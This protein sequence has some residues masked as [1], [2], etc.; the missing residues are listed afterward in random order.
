M[1]ILTLLWADEDD[2]A[3]LRQL[4]DCALAFSGKGRMV[5]KE[6]SELL[7]LIKMNCVL[8]ARHKDE[9]MG[10]IA[11]VDCRRWE[12]LPL[13]HV[14]LHRLH[15]HPEGPQ[16]EIREQLHERLVAECAK[17]NIRLLTATVPVERSYELDQM[18]KL[19]YELNELPQLL[20]RFP[21]HYHLQFKGSVKIKETQIV[22]IE[23]SLPGNAKDGRLAYAA[24]NCLPLEVSYESWQTKGWI[25]LY[26]KSEVEVASLRIIAMTEHN[27][28]HKDKHHR[29]E[30]Q[31]LFE[32]AL[33]I[34]K[35]LHAK[36]VTAYFAPTLELADNPF[37]RALDA[38]AT[39][40]EMAKS[41]ELKIDIMPS[42]PKSAPLFSSAEDVQNLLAALDNEELFG[43]RLNDQ[44]LGKVETF[45][46]NW[47]N[48]LAHLQISEPKE[49]P[50]FSKWWELLGNQPQIISILCPKIDET[51]STADLI[52]ELRTT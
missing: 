47:K 50:P 36:R 45:L 37:D 19:H 12:D 32:N 30:A 11:Y 41:L 51:H 21:R 29:F 48:G 23:D 27:I 26:E 28:V 9:L 35:R 17:Y 18:R 40:G 1:A 46:C 49:K 6:R 2:M 7:Q 25:Y 4:T 20:K 42:P 14:H 44:S 38:F 8:V 15:C 33:E 52:D 22:F 31:R 43:L 24:E 16:Q 34:A 5:E 10:Y 13:G 3:E 39:F